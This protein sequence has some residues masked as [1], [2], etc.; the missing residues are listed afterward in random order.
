MRVLVIFFVVVVIDV[1][2]VGIPNKSLEIDN[3]LV[4]GLGCRGDV[5][6]LPGRCARVAGEM[7]KGCRGD[8]ERSKRKVNS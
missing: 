2:G 6:R 7:C 3:N 8:V 1:V 4:V 5:Q